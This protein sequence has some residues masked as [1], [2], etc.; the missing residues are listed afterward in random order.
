MRNLASFALVLGLV[1]CRGSNSGDDTEQPDGNTTSEDVTIQEIQ[2]DSMPACE[3]ANPAACV[4]LKIKGVVVTAIDSFGGRTGDFW[5]QEPGGGPFS[6]VQVFGAPLDQVAALAVGDI[7]DISGAQKAEFALSSDM[8]GNKLTELE[9]IEGGTMTVT[10]TGGTMQLEP[11]VVDALAIGQMGDFMARHAEWEKWEGVLVKVTNVQAFSTQE[12]ITSMGQC[13]DTTY[14]RFDVTGDVQVQSSLAA[15]PSPNVRSGDCFSSVTGVVGYFFDYQ[16]LPRTTAEIGTGGNA[17]PTE[18]QMAT[19]EDNVDNDGNGFKD[20]ADNRCIT[21]SATCRT[22]T[23]INAI[24]TA[25]TPPTG[26]IELQNVVVAA[27]SKPSG[28][29]TPTPKNMWVQSGLTAGANDGVYVFGPGS[30]LAAF[31]PGTRVTIIGTVDEFNDATG[32]GTLTEIRALSITA[33]TGTTGTVVPVTGQ[34]VATLNADGTG[35][36]YEGV[37][38]TLTNVKVTAVGTTG[39]GGTFGVGDATQSG[40]TFKTD[41]D[42][43]L[44]NSLNA[45]YA[46]ITG[47]W[48]YLPFNNTWGFLPLSAGTGTGTCQ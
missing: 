20:C 3:P 14:Q 37:L 32:T 16:I 41:D 8:S 40:T 5:V 17:C 43:F 19:C 7:V 39:T 4:E 25:T 9:P 47:V 38:V 26:G 35:E 34:T 22:A 23:T 24:Q 44:L 48:S 36:P 46:T 33:G 10:K 6:G 45:C 29:G 1:A 11:A 2:N 30:S 31:T 18:N 42:I 12:C 15:M 21:A 28:S 27:L 13:N